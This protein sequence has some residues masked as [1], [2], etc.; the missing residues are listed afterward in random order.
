MCD[1][2]RFKKILPSLIDRSLTCLSEREL[3]GKHISDAGANV[4][5]LSE[6]GF[7]GKRHFG[8]SQFEL[9]VELSEVAGDNLLKF[10]HRREALCFHVLLSRQA[11]HSAKQ[12]HEEQQRKSVSLSSPC[13]GS[14]MGHQWAL[15]GTPAGIKR[16]DARAVRAAP[17]YEARDKQQDGLRGIRAVA[18]DSARPSQDIG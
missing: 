15:P 9:A 14:A 11:A 16:H 10:D 2:P 4:V 7:W 17:V 1:V 8:D 6:V 18:D 13:W 12:R 5:M 3:S